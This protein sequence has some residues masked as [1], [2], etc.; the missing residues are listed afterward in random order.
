MLRVWGVL[1][2]SSCLTARAGWPFPSADGV[3]WRYRL[4]SEPNGSSAVLLRRIVAPKSDADQETLAVETSIDGVASSTESLK[5][6]GNAVLATSRRAADGSLATFE[7]PATLLPANLGPGVAWNTRAEVAGVQ[8]SLPA[9]IIGEESIQLPAGAFLAW[10]VHGEQG[11][12][13]STVADRWF[14]KQVGWVKESVTQR[15]PTGEL[16]LR[17]TLELIALPS[18]NPEISPSP[19]PQLKK[20]EGS[21]STSSEGDQLTTISADALQIV[22]RWRVHGALNKSKVRAVWIAEDAGEIV[23]AEYK[24]DEATAVVTSPEATGTFTLERPEDGWAPGKYRVE[25]Y[26]GNVLAETVKLTIE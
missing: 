21:V 15:S 18:V 10:R 1:L 3:L 17:N 19:A 22:A 7:P 9:R 25:F 13:I 8:V 6:D 26:V 4:T 23:P 5:S 20:L 14:V 11:G 12:T 2:V 16:L 24:V